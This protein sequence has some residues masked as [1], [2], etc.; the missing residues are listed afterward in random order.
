M[1]KKCPNCKRSIPES[2]GEC[3]ICNDG[4]PAVYNIEKEVQDE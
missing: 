2:V 3:V 1:N 4:I